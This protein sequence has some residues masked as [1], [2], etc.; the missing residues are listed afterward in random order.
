MNDKGHTD[1]QNTAGLWTQSHGMEDPTQIRY[2]TPTAVPFWGVR[3][4]GAEIKAQEVASIS[5]TPSR[6]CP[7]PPSPHPP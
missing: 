3:E 5:V 2:A 6:F 7:S 4:N 1:R